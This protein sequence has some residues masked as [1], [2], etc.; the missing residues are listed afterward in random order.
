MRDCKTSTGKEVRIITKTDLI[1]K[2]KLA[3]RL[4]G[5]MA[6]AQGFVWDEIIRYGYDSE[7]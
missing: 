1:S 5:I 3:L 6:L 7:Y 4:A 2:E